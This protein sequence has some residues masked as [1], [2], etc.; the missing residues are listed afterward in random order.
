MS[1]TDKA[2][3]LAVRQSGFLHELRY[4]FDPP[5]E[6]LVKNKGSW[7]VYYPPNQYDSE[8]GFSIRMSYGGAVDYAKMFGGVVLRNRDAQR[9][10]KGATN[11]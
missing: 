1:I 6:G 8:G 11:E 7:R 3:A 10:M 5:N 2:K 9:L 4:F